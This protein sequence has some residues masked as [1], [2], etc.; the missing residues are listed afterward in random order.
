MDKVICCSP[1][2]VIKLFTVSQEIYEGPCLMGNV[3]IT[4]DGGAA[5]ADVYDG[6]N[7]KA[8]RKLHLEA[9]QG[10]TFSTG[11]HQD[12]V[13]RRGIYVKINNATTYLTVTYRNLDEH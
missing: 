10:V 5:D 2:Y 6:I 12:H 7:D 13:M 3:I 11:A 4:G 8:E 1:E 9:L